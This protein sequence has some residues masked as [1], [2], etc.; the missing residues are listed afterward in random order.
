[1][2]KAM[3][4]GNGRILM[5]VLGIVGTLAVGSLLGVS[6]IARG[7]WEQVDTNT[8]TNA[9]QDAKFEALETTVNRIDTNVTKLLESI[10]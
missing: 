7:Q 5:W 6:G 9:V 4:N 10:P 1:M 8:T 2:G 3:V